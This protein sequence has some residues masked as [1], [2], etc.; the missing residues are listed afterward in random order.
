[1]NQT[2]G[3]EI[4]KKEMIKKKIGRKAEFE[5]A[6]KSPMEKNKVQYVC[7]LWTAGFACYHY[8]QNTASVKHTH[9]QT[10]N[11]HCLINPAPISQTKLYLLTTEN[12]PQI[13]TRC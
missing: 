6:E 1:M 2:G 8:P 12:H 13:Q 5:K 4:D 3:D 11:M 7:M 10:L 9:T